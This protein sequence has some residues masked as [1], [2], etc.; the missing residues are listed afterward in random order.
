LPTTGALEEPEG[1]AFRIL[2]VGR[3]AREK[4]LM[5]LPETMSR[6]LSS[7]NDVRLE[8]V[9]DG[10]MRSPLEAEIQRY[11]IGDSVTFVG[12]LLREVIGSHYRNADV[13]VFPS[14]SDTQALVL[15]EAALASLPIVFSDP[16]INP[17]AVPGFSSV[18]AEPTVEGYVHALKGILSDRAKA[19][20]LGENACR[21]ALTYTEER[22]GLH[23]AQVIRS[24][25]RT[26]RQASGQ[27][28]RAQKRRP[29]LFLERGGCQ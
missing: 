13:F 29:W 18:L 16:S 27:T 6:L 1:A 7:G 10:E 8:I 17:V 14:M 21:L 22:Q 9:G 12:P 15:N 19:Q 4:N 2:Y 5:I 11:R 23:M 3:L 20:T 26:N 28:D 24:V 25:S